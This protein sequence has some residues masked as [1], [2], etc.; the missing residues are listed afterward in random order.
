MKAYAATQRESV[1]NSTWFVAVFGFWA[2]F[3]IYLIEGFWR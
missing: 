1:F 3:V 2:G